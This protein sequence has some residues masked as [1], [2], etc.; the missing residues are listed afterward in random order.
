MNK[1]LGQSD[2]T[3]GDLLVPIIRD[4]L[5]A[6]VR[7]AMTR[8]RKDGRWKLHELWRAIEKEISVIST[9]AFHI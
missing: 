3:Y 8:A 7:Q 2:E 1:S 9:A 5:S 4:K 6:A